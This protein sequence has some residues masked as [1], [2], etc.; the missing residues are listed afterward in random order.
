[1]IAQSWVTW[2]PPGQQQKDLAEGVSG[3]RDGLC[4]EKVSAWVHH[5]TKTIL[6]SKRYTFNMTRGCCYEGGMKTG[7]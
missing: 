2:P 6:G 1:M 4:S 3:E 5:F 7:W